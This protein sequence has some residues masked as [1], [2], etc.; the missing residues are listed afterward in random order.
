MQ[1]AEEEEEE[2]YERKFM[3]KIYK[4]SRYDTII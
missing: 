4:S 3:R 1:H 2:E